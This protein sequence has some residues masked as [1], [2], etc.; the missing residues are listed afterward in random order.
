MRKIFTEI[1]VGFSIGLVMLASFAMTFL[2]FA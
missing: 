1:V 2:N